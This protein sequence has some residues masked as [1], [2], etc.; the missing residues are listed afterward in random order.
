MSSFKKIDESINEIVSAMTANG[1]EIK[2]DSGNPVPVTARG[3]TGMA[4]ISTF[5]STS[6]LELRAAASTRKLLTVF[7]EGAG[8]LHILY[9]DGTASTS[10]YSVRLASGDFL[11][12][13]N[14]T[15]R[16]VAIFASAG[17]AR[18]TEIL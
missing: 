6:S 13:E 17:T 7:N 1:V 5:T 11:E 4:T 14:Y 12:I 16:V 8:T 18:V 3:G 9:G 15:G 2:N 10:N